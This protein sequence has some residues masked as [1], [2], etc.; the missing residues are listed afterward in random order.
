L[1]QSNRRVRDPYARWCGRGGTARCPPIPIEVNERT[2]SFAPGV[3]CA[4]NTRSLGALDRPQRRGC[5][6]SISGSVEELAHQDGWVGGC[7]SIANSIGLFPPYLKLGRA[8]GVRHPSSTIVWRPNDYAGSPRQAAGRSPG[9][10]YFAGG[11]RHARRTKACG[12]TPGSFPSS[13]SRPSLRLALRSSPSVSP[14]AC[15]TRS[16]SWP[17][18]RPRAASAASPKCCDPGEGRARRS[19]AWRR[20]PLSDRRHH[21]STCECCRCPMMVPRV[22]GWTPPDGICVPR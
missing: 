22:M 12:T 4:A 10:R 14:A 8:D 17:A 16:S 11:C 13:R 9:A 1:T 15:S 20:P 21:P 18:A 3:E 2:S 19:Q 7:A 6:P 5:W